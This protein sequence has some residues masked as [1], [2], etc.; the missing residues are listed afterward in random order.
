M[1]A[2]QGYSGDKVKELCLYG[3]F[4][5]VC[6]ALSFLESL[7]PLDFIAPGVKLGLSNAVCVIFAY[8]GDFK[9]AL[10]INS[11][12]IILS[13]LLF[14]SAVSFAFSFSAGIISLLFTCLMAKINFFSTVAV[15]TAAGVIHNIVQMFAGIIFIGTGVLFYFPVLV[16]TGAL[17][18]A[19][20]G[21]ISN[22]IFKKIKTNQ[23]K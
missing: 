18:G 10:L 3:V 22:L 20:V 7:L 17:S 19:T 16:V 11:V 4:S 8:K 6:L 1:S 9:G 23:K 12:R 21:I 14:G 5:A 13:A 2:K 15:S